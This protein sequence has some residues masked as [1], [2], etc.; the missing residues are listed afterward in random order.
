MIAP[1]C[2]HYHKF[3]MQRTNTSSANIINHREKEDSISFSI[4]GVVLSVALFIISFSG[5]AFEVSL[6]RL[7][8]VIFLQG[9]V[10][11]LISLS[12]AGLGIGAV[13]VYYLTEKSLG[14][15]FHLLVDQKTCVLQQ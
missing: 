10:Y 7:Y 2:E 14:L 6:T 9:Y 3:K 5:L 13:L 8:S 15:L 11:L 12:M 1:S 4:E